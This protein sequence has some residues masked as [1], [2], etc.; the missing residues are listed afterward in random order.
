MNVHFELVILFFSL[1]VFF[2]LSRQQTPLFGMCSFS[3]LTI[4]SW[5]LNYAVL[6]PGICWMHCWLNFGF[7]HFALRPPSCIQWFLF[8]YTCVAGK[9]LPL[10]QW[11]IEAGYLIGYFL[12]F[13]DL[14][15]VYLSY[16]SFIRYKWDYLFLDKFILEKSIHGFSD[17]MEIVL[18]WGFVLFTFRLWCLYSLF[19]EQNCKREQCS[20]GHFYSSETFL[21]IFPMNKQLYFTV[22]QKYKWDRHYLMHWP[23][24]IFLIDKSIKWINV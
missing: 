9:T 6:L 4:W 15:K 18:F 8:L 17:E 19:S 2:F 7:I 20:S 16:F 23:A 12:R 1:A 11:Q 21:N 24:G 13:L 3:F 10:F 22:S 5:P 14:G